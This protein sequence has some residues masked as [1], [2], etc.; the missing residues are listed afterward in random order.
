MLGFS[1]LILC[2]IVHQ[3]SAAQK[4]IPW[5]VSSVFTRGKATHLVLADSA[6]QIV[7]TA[8]NRSMSLDEYLRSKPRNEA[9]INPTD[10]IDSR[11]THALDGGTFTSFADAVVLNAMSRLAESHNQDLDVKSARD[12]DSRDFEQ[13]N[14]ILV[15]SASSNPWVNLFNHRLNFRESDD[16]DHP[17]IKSLVNLHPKPGEPL[18]LE[19]KAPD[20]AVREDYVDVAVVQGLGGQGSVL[21]IQ[22]LRHESTEA[23][24]RVLTDPEG[25]KML[26]MAFAKA[27]YPTPPLYFETVL[28]TSAVAG[29]P[30]VKSV[31]ALRVLQP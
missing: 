20:D 30:Q 23:A 17:G 19:G 21:L 31:V 26:K 24:G 13:G 2:F 1:T 12:I 14:F 15:G 6:Y 25:S 22:G 27:G 4:H 29:V 9:F 28:A 5:P 7:A 18:R 8:N 16:P 11:L 3:E 10:S